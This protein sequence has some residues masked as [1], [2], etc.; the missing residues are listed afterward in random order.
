M[1]QIIFSDE[2]VKQTILEF[3]NLIKEDSEVDWDAIEPMVEAKLSFACSWC[4]F[5]GMKSYCPVSYGA[6][7]VAQ[8]KAKVITKQESVTKIDIKKLSIDS[9]KSKDE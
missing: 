4:P 5:L 3:E 1:K 7:Y 6:G 8:R 9:A 2:D